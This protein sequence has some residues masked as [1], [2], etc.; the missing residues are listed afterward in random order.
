MN[1]EIQISMK[2][3]DIF[4]IQSSWETAEAGPIYEV[5]E[6]PNWAPWLAASQN[7]LAGRVD[8]FKQGQLLL[9]TQEEILLASL[10]TNRIDWNGDP[11]TLPCWDDVAGDP[12]TY[13]NTYK[14]NGNT[15]CLMSMN[16]NPSFQGIGLAKE[17]IAGIKEVALE[18]GLANLIGS[19]RPNQFGKFKSQN[20]Q[21]NLDFE[22]YCK[23]QRPDGWPI[24]GWLRSLMKNG[25]EPLIVDRKAMSVTVP[26][27]EFDDYMNNYNP[28]IWKQ[29]DDDVWECGEV[30]QW[31][32]DFHSGLA[33]YK[34][35]NLWGK[36]PLK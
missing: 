31:T 10:S 1:K 12:T 4:A 22:T 28:H 26:I 3:E 18:L 6:K 2:D 33:V 29:V 15:L 16:V 14:P 17:M 24:D 13:V 27:N 34:E 5:L 20:D 11:T 25:M 32:V 23:M 8:I 30:G 7:T 36:I 35:C 9:K 21:W 19:F